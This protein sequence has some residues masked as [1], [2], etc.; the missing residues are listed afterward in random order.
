MPAAAVIPALQVCSHIVAVKTPVVENADRL[1][2]LAPFTANKSGRLEYGY[3]Y[4]SAQY[5]IISSHEQ[6]EREPSGVNLFHGERWNAQTHER[7]TKAKA[8]T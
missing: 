2:V 5:E 6:D 7:E 8:F 3:M 1:L 4:D